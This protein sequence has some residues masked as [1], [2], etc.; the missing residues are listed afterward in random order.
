MKNLMHYGDDCLQLFEDYYS[1]VFG[2]GFD[3]DQ[4]TKDWIRGIDDFECFAYTVIDNETVIVS[5][6][7]NGDI[8]GQQPIKDFMTETLNYIREEIAN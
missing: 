4:E 5:D 7:I 3:V 8:I 1:D 6:S 2:T